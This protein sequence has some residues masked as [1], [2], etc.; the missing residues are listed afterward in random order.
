MS[1]SPDGSLLATV[2]FSGKLSVWAVPSLRQLRAWEQREQVGPTL[3]WCHVLCH[4]AV[5]PR[6]TS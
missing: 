6:R 1:L 5:L 2:H 3:V 4:M